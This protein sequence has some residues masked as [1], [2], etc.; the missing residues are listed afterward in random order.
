MT[1]SIYCPMIFAR[2]SRFSRDLLM[3]ALIL[4]WL[5]IPRLAS[6]MSRLMMIRNT[7]RLCMALIHRVFYSNRSELFGGDLDL[8]APYLPGTVFLQLLRGHSLHPHKFQ[9]VFTDHPL[10]R[11][12]PREDAGIQGE[13]FGAED[14][15]VDMPY[16]VDHEDQHRFVRMERFGRGDDFSR[17]DP[18]DECRCPEDGPRHE[19]QNSPDQDGPVLELLHVIVPVALCRVVFKTEVVLNVVNR[20]LIIL[21]RDKHRQLP[22]PAD[23]SNHPDKHVRQEFEGK[24]KSR[25]SVDQPDVVD[26]SQLEDKPLGRFQMPEPLTE[27]GGKKN[28]GGQDDSPMFHDPERAE[29]PESFLYPPEFSA[30]CSSPSSLTG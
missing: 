25:V 18:C 9:R 7:I 28:H 10:S 30:H 11:D 20:I 5:M 16:G 29:P 17:Q 23:H 1:W 27:A 21:S 2:A 13:N 26:S 14:R 24:Q 6:M 19:H 15:I 12:I 4:K 22:F 3:L 8:Q